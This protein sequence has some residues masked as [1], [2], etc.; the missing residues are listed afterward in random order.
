MRISDWSS[1]V[2]SSDLSIRINGVV[3]KVTSRLN[4]LDLRSVSPV[5]GDVVNRLTSLV[6]SNLRR[7]NLRGHSFRL[8]SETRTGNTGIAFHTH[9]TGKTFLDR[10]S[11]V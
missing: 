7:R 9:R 11:V 6:N 3:S 2:C 1:D 8:R 5:R 10:K 4:D